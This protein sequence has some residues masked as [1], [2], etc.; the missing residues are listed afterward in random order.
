M[1]DEK[2]AEVKWFLDTDTVPGATAG[3]PK[4]SKGVLCGEGEVVHE[5]HGE[6]AVRGEGDESE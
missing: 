2:V 6:E 5:P 1:G 4:P 3:P